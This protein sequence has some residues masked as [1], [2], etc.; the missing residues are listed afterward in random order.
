[1]GRVGH[2]EGIRVPG[3]AEPVSHY[4]DAVRAGDTVYI[5]G[6]VSTDERGQVVGVGD[7]VAQ[8]RHIF[9]SLGLVLEAV[10]GTPA[11]VAKVTVFMRDV[12]QRPAINP[13]RKAF[14][15]AHRPASTLVE[16][17]RLIHD[18]LLLEVEAVAIVPVRGG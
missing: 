4:T 3:L 12:S 10:G 15:G 5:S 14:F 16:V 2:L 18:D 8:A 7:V 1:M 17:S 13:V 6:L 11:D 9:H